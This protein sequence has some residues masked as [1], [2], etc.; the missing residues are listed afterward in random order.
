LTDR[1]DRRRL[2]VAADL[3]RAV[4][5]LGFLLVQ[6][7]SQVWLV[8]ALLAAMAVFSAV[9]EPASVAALPNLVEPED[10]VTANALAGSSWGT[11][12]AV[13]AAIGGV[14]T[15]VFGAGTAVVID[16]LSFAASAAM[17][18][19]I[20]RSFSEPG[21]RTRE[22]AG[23]GAATVET[24]RYARKDHRVLALLA[25]KFGWGVAG[26]VL[27]LIP[28]LATG[29]FHAGDV[30]IGMLM[31]ARGVG[32]LIG[33]F[34]GR[35]SLGQGDRRLFST[36]GVALVVFGTGYALV[37]LAPGLLLALPALTL[38]HLGGGAQWT[39]SSYGLQKI[40]PDHIRGRIF[41]FD[42]MLVTLTFGTSSVLTGWLAET[43]GPGPTAIGLGCTAIAWAVV[44]TWLTTGVRRATL[45]EGC[46][47]APELAAAAV[48]PGS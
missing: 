26:G 17:I 6:T 39:L 5:C 2:M 8:Y 21:T 13:G 28:L 19:P 29:P 27:V 9:F 34:A 30:A 40:V 42:G 32:A 1:W 44:W 12:L 37:G 41:A 20:R 43:Y 38:A 4:L 14:V 35:A 31:A 33:P 15:A 48:P 36:I 22:H 16:A 24:A 45:I 47:V 46:G 25:V 10:L 3:A 7:A 11:M 23:I 18:A